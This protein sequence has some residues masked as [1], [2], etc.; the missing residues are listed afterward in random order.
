MGPQKRPAAAVCRRPASA[1]PAP[2]RKRPA[3]S[4]GQELHVQRQLE[5]FP[6]PNTWSELVPQ[7]RLHRPLK[8]SMPCVGI[9]G[10]GF[11]LDAIGA[12]YHA[13]NVYDLDARYE[14]HLRSHLGAD[15]V[16]HL[17][18]EAGDLT[19]HL[20]RRGT[21]C[22]I[23][24]SGPPCP[25]WAGQGCHAGA[26]DVR[27]EVF[28][29]VLKYCIRAGRLNALHAVVLENVKGILQ[30]TDKGSG[31]S[32]MESVLQEVRKALPDFDWQVA[33]LKAQEYKLGQQRTRV[34]LRGLRRVFGEVPP[35]LAPFGGTPLEAFLNPLLP[36]VDRSQ[37][38]KHMA[39]NLQDA[40][41]ELLEKRDKG[42]LAE[43][44]VVCFPLDRG[45]NRAYVRQYTTNLAPTLTTSNKYLFVVSVGCLRKPEAARRFFRFLDSTERLTLQGFKKNVLSASSEALRVKAS[46]NAYPVPLLAAV[47]A[48]LLQQLAHPS[49]RCHLDSRPHGNV[50]DAD[51]VASRFEEA[52]ARLATG[53]RS[54]DPP[55]AASQRQ[56]L[57]PWMSGSDSDSS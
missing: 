24:V 52:M 39:V 28:V 49:A 47:L 15:C 17:G 8:V 3:R 36:G 5:D 27:A 22:D 23:L 57:D 19:K 51:L 32:F 42:Q 31:P 30:K 4:E 38:T 6:E 35:P 48:P 25:P 18:S 33:V 56:A 43:T 11:A 46:G 54:C 44:D 12:E 37:L 53:A 20:Y 14:Q 2:A 21:P 26:A 16:L 40:E 10:C 29:E 41:R 34:F 1:A 13:V 50:R 45:S 9:D 55:A 7:V